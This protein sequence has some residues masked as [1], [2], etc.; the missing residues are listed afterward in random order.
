MKTAAFFDLDLTLLRVNS[1]HLWVRRDLRLG[2]ITRGQ[3]LQGLLYLLAYRLNVLDVE[4]AI[5]KGLSTI[6]G[7][8]EDVVREWTREWYYQDVAREVAPGGARTLA[9]HRAAGHRLVLLTSSSPYEAAV[10]AE[11]MEL[12]AW[13]SST[14][15]V[16]DGIFTGEVV[17]PLCY[18]SG[19][20]VHARQFAERHAIDLGRSYF[21]TDSASDLPMLNAVGHPR[22]VNPDWRLAWEAR[23]RGWAVLDWDR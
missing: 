6:K 21:Y 12:D 15:E 14:Y 4:A 5:R 1:G 9:E 2:R 7:L 23:K 19:K 20:V 11:H 16:V 17:K 3:Y 22:V 13:I 10:A 18:N 8:R